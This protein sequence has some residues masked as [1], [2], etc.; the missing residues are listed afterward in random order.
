MQDAIQAGIVRGDAVGHLPALFS[1]AGQQI[2]RK[3]LW[4]NMLLVSNVLRDPTQFLFVA[5]QQ[6]HRCAVTRIRER[7]FPPNAIAGASDQ[8]NAVLQ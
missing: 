8:N 4:L 1:G 5:S 3:P 6:N 7:G 2:E